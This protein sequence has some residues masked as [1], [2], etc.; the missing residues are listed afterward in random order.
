MMY[1]VLYAVVSEPVEAHGR[2]RKKEGS[3]SSIEPRSKG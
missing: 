2:N 3:V 1:G